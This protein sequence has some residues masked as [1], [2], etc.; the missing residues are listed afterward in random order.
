MQWNFGRK[1]LENFLYISKLSGVAK[2]QYKG[3]EKD[4]KNYNHCPAL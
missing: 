4:Y 2:Q 3:K 1:A